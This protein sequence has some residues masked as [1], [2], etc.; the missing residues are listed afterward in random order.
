MIKRILLATLFLALIFGGAIGFKLYKRAAIRDYLASHSNPTVPLRATLSRAELWDQRLP[1]IGTLRA[2]QGIEIRSEVNAVIRRLHVKSRQQVAAGDL[3]VELDDTIDRATLKSAGVRLERARSNFKRDSALFERSLLSEEQF[4]D[5]RSELQSA[6]ALVE[7][8]Q[9]VIDKKTIRAPFDGTVGIHNLSEGQY[10]EQGSEL[11]TL[12]ALDTLYL[13]LNLPEKELER[14]RPGQRVE[15][16][17]PSHGATDFEGLVRYIDARVETST[18]NILVRV[19]VEN[20]LHVLLPGMFASAN[21]ILD[22]QLYVVTLPREAV[23]FSL[24]GETVY[25]LE[26]E[27]ADGGYTARRRAVSS[28][29]ARDGRVAVSGINA[30]ALLA[31][32]TQNRLLEGTPVEIVNLPEVAG[33]AD[34]DSTDSSAATAPAVTGSPAGQAE[35]P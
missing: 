1:A 9:G 2:R 23:A 33:D 30:G 4:E 8:T 14:L 29:E 6:E 34:P 12:Q 17:V 26:Q 11:V 3:L 27:R 19:E 16:R 32:D 13:D 15:F 7:E 31:L 25:L 18:R 5:S 22:E 24:Y 35:T 21:I 28:G 10:L 20:P